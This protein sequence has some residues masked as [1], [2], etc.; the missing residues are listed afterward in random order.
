MKNEYKASLI[1]KN[2]AYLLAVPI[3]I[4]GFYII[5]HG[6]L[7]PG[8]GFPGGAVL[9]SAVALFLV[10]FGSGEGKKIHDD[11]FSVL[12]TIGLVSFVVLAFLGIS[13]TF[14]HNFMANSGQLF[15]NIVSFGVNS[16]YL[17]TGGVIPLMNMAVGLEVFAAL[18]LI[19]VVIYAYGE[20]RK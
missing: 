7:T 6:H 14:F 9:A 17:N 12:E 16:G 8:G 4:F 3:I 5:L 11:F 10:S 13:A 15:G 19:V 2:I 18:S 1:V 20:K